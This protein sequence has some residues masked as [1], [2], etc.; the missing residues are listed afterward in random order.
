[1]K[2]YIPASDVSTV[3]IQQKTASQDADFDYSTA[4]STLQTNVQADIQP[5]SPRLVESETGGAYR[6]THK[7]F[8]EV[9]SDVVSLY[10]QGVVNVVDSLRT[11]QIR[12]IRSYNSHM[13][14]DL[15]EQL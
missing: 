1:M 15:E 14:T 2:L 13:E 8:S 11:Y 9:Y 4:T 7:M 6:I 12:G 5:Q 10:P 3:S